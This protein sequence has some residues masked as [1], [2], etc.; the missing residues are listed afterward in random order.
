M[1]STT[2]PRAHRL[3][4]WPSHFAEFRGYSGSKDAVDAITGFLA[5]EL[6]RRKIRVTAIVPGFAE[7][8]GGMAAV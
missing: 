7:I 8:G 6:G 1:Q 5:R 3:C 4:R 2:R